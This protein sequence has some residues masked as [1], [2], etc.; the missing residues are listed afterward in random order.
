MPDVPPQQAASDD[1]SVQPLQGYQDDFDDE[2]RDQFANEAPDDPS[3]VTPATREE[4]REGLAK[5]AGDDQEGGAPGTPE[6]DDWREE[7]E[8]RDEEA[9]ARGPM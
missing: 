6:E 9:G 1:T 2:K 3:R 7:I 8:D 4:L 5:T